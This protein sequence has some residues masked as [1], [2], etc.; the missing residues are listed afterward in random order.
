MAKVEKIYLVLVAL[1]N[2]EFSLM[3][4]QFMELGRS[5]VETKISWIL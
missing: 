2:D 5:R 3:E 1:Q 4:D